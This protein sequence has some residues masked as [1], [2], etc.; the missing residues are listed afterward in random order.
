M[1][2]LNGFPLLKN[3]KNLYLILGDKQVH[4]EA[5]SDTDPIGGH[6]PGGDW[7]GIWLRARVRVRL[8]TG[9]IGWRQLPQET[10][11]CQHR[12]SLRHRVHYLLAGELDWALTFSQ[13]GTNIN[14][15]THTHT[16]SSPEGWC[17]TLLWQRVSANE[18]SLINDLSSIIELMC[19]N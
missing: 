12:L 15:H 7:I 19:I 9:L 11:Q 5:S 14:T 4:W 6:G 10:E 3:V 1:W 13:S 18:F 8:R 2:T 17:I 16:Q